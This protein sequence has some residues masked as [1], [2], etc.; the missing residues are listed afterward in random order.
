[1]FYVSK[2]RKTTKTVWVTDTKDGVEEAYTN[3]DILKISK[4]IHILGIKNGIV[5]RS[6]SLRDILRYYK[7]KGSL[8]GTFKDADWKIVEKKSNILEQYLGENDFVVIPYGVEVLDEISLS[9]ENLPTSYHK[10]GVSIPASVKKILRRAFAN[11]RGLTEISLPDRL[12]VLDFEAFSCCSNLSEIYIPDSVTHLGE[13]VFRGCLRLKRVRLPQNLV[14]IPIQ[15]FESTGIVDF[16]IPETVKCIG[17]QA[18][19]HCSNLGHIEIPEGV[20][21]IQWGAFTACESLH[22]VRLPR[23]LR[24]L[25]AFAFDMCWRLREVDMSNCQ[26]DEISYG[27]FSDCN[28]L[29][30]VFLPK[31]LKKLGS[32]SFSEQ[33]RYRVVLPRGAYVY[34]DAFGRNAGVTLEYYD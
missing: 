6:F 29:E 26:V 12:E 1:M 27:V 19:S 22:S 4:S 3:E 10:S 13:G 15:L 5:E 11:C 31:C 16:R 8:A 17:K 20:E 9:E 34:D 33:G 21:D 23:T 28:S 25:G 2:V 24:M 32:M 30:R 7:V 18:F 14:E